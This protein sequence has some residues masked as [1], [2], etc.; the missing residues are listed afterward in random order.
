MVINYGLKDQK[1]A[2]FAE[3][4]MHLVA[5]GWAVFTALYSLIAGLFN[6][7]NLWC[8]IAPLPGDCLD[9]RRFGNEGNCARGDNAWIYRW[10]FYFAPLW[11]CIFFASTY[12]GTIQKIFLHLALELPANLLFS[13][14]ST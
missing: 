8:W 6:N 3:P 10:A 1:I 9:S 4:C 12:I 11:F 7:A 5:A 14:P 2:E 13:L